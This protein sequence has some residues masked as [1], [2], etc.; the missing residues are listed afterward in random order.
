MDCLSNIITLLQQ[1]HMRPTS[2]R[3]AV[4]Q[5]IADADGV[6]R[7]AEVYQQV[8]RRRRINRV[9]VYRIL[10]EFTQ[11]GIIRRLSLEG[12]SRFYELAAGCIPV[13]PHFQCQ[14]CG[15]VQCLEPM[16]MERI[17]EEL[18]GPMG[19][20]AERI[21]IRVNGICHK[22]REKYGK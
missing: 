18:K 5:V 11:R 8:L 4:F 6:L 7:S 21:E 10:E 13:H 9:T 14:I 16:N 15:V 20:M 3:L 1:H 17:W 22:C 19:N 12:R 2:A